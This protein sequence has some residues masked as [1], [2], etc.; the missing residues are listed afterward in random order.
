VTCG[1]QKKDNW[2][3]KKKR[4]FKWRI[5]VRGGDS[6]KCRHP[7][8]KGRGSVD[9]EKTHCGPQTGTKDRLKGEVEPTARKLNRGEQGR[10]EGGEGA[11]GVLDPLGKR[12]GKS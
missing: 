9:E 7:V 11:E 10:R 3:A 4:P 2:D 5:A 1:Q 12:N 6:I 8:D